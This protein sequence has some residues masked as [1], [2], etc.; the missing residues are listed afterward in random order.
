VVS[1]LLSRALQRV[2]CHQY[3]EA[4]AD[5]N[6]WPEDSRDE[7]KDNF[8]ESIKSYSPEFATRLAG[9]ATAAPK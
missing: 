5:L 4:L 1:A 6:Q 8:A 2:L 3:D 9:G 7:M